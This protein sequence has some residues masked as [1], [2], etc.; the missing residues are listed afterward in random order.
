MHISLD[1]ALGRQ[2]RLNSVGESVLQI[3]E[4]PALGYSLRSLTGGDPKVVRVRRSSD[5][6]ESD[7]TVS[8]ISSGALLDFVKTEAVTYTSD[9][10]TDTDGWSAANGSAAVS[11]GALELTPNTVSTT[12]HVTE[13]GLVGAGEK[14]RVSFDVKI[15]SGQSL[16]NGFRFVEVSGTTIKQVNNQA[17]GDFV[18]YSEE[19]TSTSTGILRLFASKDGNITFA[20]DDSEKILIK[21]IVVTSIDENGFVE[22]WY[23]QSGNSNDAV[24]A[25]AGSQPKIVNAGALLADG[26]DF[27]GS[28]DILVAASVSGFGATVSLFE[29]SIRDGGAAAVV[30][31]GSSAATTNTN[32]GLVE[33]G[34]NTQAS[35]RNTTSR[36]VNASV[37]GETRLGFAVTTGQTST[38]VGAL[39]GTLVETTDDYGDDFTSGELDT[40]F[41]GK[42]RGGSSTEFNGH[43]REALVYNTDQSAN[44]DAVE[45]NIANHYNITLV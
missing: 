11:D 27:D 7:F 3:A 26:I 42:I 6:A 34:S 31:M 21:N 2:R 18:S 22:T 36:T 9:F 19:F 39:G 32:F 45:A 10:S 1:S 14:V 8:G 24:Q 17:Q 30:S 15:P 40:I 33:A 23:D 20:G 28:D 4:S 5:N 25:T 16:V 29:A 35:V 44:R 38:K 41:L 13:S 12:H 43:I 37:S